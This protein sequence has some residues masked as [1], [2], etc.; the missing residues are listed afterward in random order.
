MTSPISSSSEVAGCGLRRMARWPL[1]P[2]RAGPSHPRTSRPRTPT[3]P[4]TASARRR[5]HIPN[6]PCAQATLVRGRSPRPRCRLCQN[7]PG[8]II[9]L[10]AWR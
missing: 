6:P 7:E 1:P 4:W 10:R 9:R 5:H 2:R 8:G 3:S